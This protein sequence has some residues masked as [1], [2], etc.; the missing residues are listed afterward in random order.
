MTKSGLEVGGGDSGA[1]GRLWVARGSTSLP[2][3]SGVGL[4]LNP[5]R[6]L[7]VTDINVTYIY[8]YIYIYGCAYEIMHGWKS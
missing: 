5:E 3:L 4:S 1:W 6:E 7:E 2:W 8:I